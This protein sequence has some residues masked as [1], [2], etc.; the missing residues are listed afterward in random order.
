MPPLSTH[1]RVDIT[2]ATTLID[3]LSPTATYKIVLLPMALLIPFGIDNTTKYA[4]NEAT[5]YILDTSIT[6]RFFR[7]RHIT[8]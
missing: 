5:V 1:L 4:I 3:T 6:G 2:V 7:A 8:G